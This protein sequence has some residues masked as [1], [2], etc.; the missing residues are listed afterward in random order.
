MKLRTNA[1]L[2][3]Q[4][5][6]RNQ[7]K[8]FKTAL[9]GYPGDT[10]FVDLFGGSGL[11]SYTVKQVHPNSTVIYNDFDNYTER[12]NNIDTTNQL[13]SKIREIALKYEIKNY[14]KFCKESKSEVL[15]LLKKE[16]FIDF[17]TFS[18]NI[19][20]SCHYCKT[21]EEFEKETF[22]NNITQKLYDS[23]GYLKGLDV[24]KLD[25]KEL[26]RQFKDKSNVCFI[27]DPPYLS[28]DVSSYS[29]GSGEYWK[30]KDYLDVV[31]CLQSNNYI[32]FTSEKSQIVELFE[33]LK[34]KYNCINPFERA[35][36]LVVNC[37]TG[38]GG[39]YQDQCFYTIK[40]ATHTTLKF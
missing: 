24:V 13:I 31:D 22:Y 39:I 5:Q 36:K 35:E 27:V 4:G 25:Y 33:T 18:S 17:L 23:N 28:T 26:F 9:L 16:S 8:N 19:L 38:K 7:L 14:K 11:L 34:E 2:P 32:F 10:I 29:A 37:S 30:L 21:I 3:F 12:L 6:K 1:P 15:E 20:F 40:H